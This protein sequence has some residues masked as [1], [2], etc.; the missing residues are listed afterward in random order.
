M[1]L[2]YQFPFRVD[3]AQNSARTRRTLRP[4]DLVIRGSDHQ[5]FV[6][7]HL[8][9]RNSLLERPAMLGPTLSAAATVSA[10]DDI[11]PAYFR[12]VSARR[13]PIESDSAHS[14]S[15]PMLAAEDVDVAVPHAATHPSVQAL[16]DLCSA[17]G[18]ATVDAATGSALRK[19]TV[20]FI[21]QHMVHVSQLPAAHSDAR[22]FDRVISAMNSAESPAVVAD[23]Q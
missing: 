4:L 1:S 15:D 11:L 18:G 17:Q 19:E 13:A 9:A 14:K 22:A 10:I 8:I 23:G 21:H 2:Q 20:E 16:L 3:L 7:I 12:G 5:N 6:D